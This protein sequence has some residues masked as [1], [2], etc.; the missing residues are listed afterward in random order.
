MYQRQIPNLDIAKF[1]SAFLVIAIHTQP[2]LDSKPLVNLYFVQVVCRIAVPLFFVIS[3]YLFFRKLDDNR[4]YNDYENISKLKHTL[5]RLIK[6]YLI[7]SIIYLPFSYL[8]YG[9]INIHNILSYLRG[10]LFNGSYYHL[11]FFPALIFAIIM[12]YGLRKFC[13]YKVIALISLGLYLIGMSINIYG[14]YLDLGVVDTYLNIFETTRNGLFFGMF[15]VSVGALFANANENYIVLKDSLLVLIIGIILLGL[16]VSVLNKLGYMQ[17]ITSMFASLVIVV[18]ALFACLLSSK[19]INNDYSKYMRSISIIIYA[20]HVIIIIL[21]GIVLPN[22]SG[23]LVYVI[24]CVVS[25]GLASIVYLL[26][27]KI[28]ILKELY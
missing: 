23:E 27:K 25:L 20:I 8:L 18:P 19:Q 17:S 14:N 26:A 4:E 28:N 6:L 12:V 24:T 15:F 10:L 3:G 22:L 9:T 11:W 1:I 5:F 7:Y 16:E 13:S 2:F 21:L